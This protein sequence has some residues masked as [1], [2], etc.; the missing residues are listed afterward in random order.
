MSKLTRATILDAI[1][2]LAQAGQSEVSS[3]DVI[4]VTY[5]SS[6]TVRRHLDALLGDGQL[7][8]SGNA[9]ASRYRLTEVVTAPNATPTE[10]RSVGLHPVW[11]PAA[12][13]LGR[14]LDV[15]L[16]ACDPVTYRRAFVEGYVPNDTWLM[17]RSLAEELHRD[18][19]LRERLPAGT[20]ARNVLEQ[21]RIDLSWSS[22]RLEGNRYTL[23][24]AEELFKRESVGS[25][26]DAVML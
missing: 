1:Q 16:A 6:A 13:E 3:S 19:S 11:S 4:N 24:E 8:R 7:T 22:S 14:K 20:Y 17:P 26:I 23:R 18:A 21:L 25:D 5:G 10:D 15:A 9:R 12:V 2:R